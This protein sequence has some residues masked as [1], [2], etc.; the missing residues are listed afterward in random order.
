MGALFSFMKSESESEEY[1]IVKS[2]ESTQ[3]K[4]QKE[5]TTKILEFF[6]ISKKEL[7]ENQMNLEEIYGSVLNKGILPVEEYA[8]NRTLAVIIYD[9]L[10]NSSKS[11]RTEELRTIFKNNSK[12]SFIRNTINWAVKKI[13]PDQSIDVNNLPNFEI[14]GR[15][16]LNQV[17]IL[18]IVKTKP[19]TGISIHGPKIVQ[20][21][22]QR[23]NNN[24]GEI[25]DAIKEGTLDRIFMNIQIKVAEEEQREKE[26][27]DGK[28]TYESHRYPYPELYFDRK[29]MKFTRYHGKEI[30]ANGDTIKV[31]D[32]VPLGVCFEECFKSPF[33]N[34]DRIYMVKKGETT[35][36]I[37]Y[38]NSTISQDQIPHEA[39]K[40]NEN[41]DFLKLA[42][43]L[44]L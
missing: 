11:K 32:K 13:F 14:K 23:I 10:N 17:G 6:D 35:D 21:V 42:N 9:Y 30:Y 4:E 28:K 27:K 40:V 26:M 43:D 5:N 2:K 25:I 38:T 29:L 33:A 7:F 18:Y 8:H 3:T 31:N 16:Y 36:G 37:C 19:E 24:E 20:H 34:C 22:L 15:V 39:I 44:K 1:D 12:Q 41:Y